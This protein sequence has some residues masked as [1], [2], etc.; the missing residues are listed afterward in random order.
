M[1]LS[2]TVTVIPV[3]SRREVMILNSSRF[4]LLREEATS[5]VPM[6]GPFGRA[7]PTSQQQAVSHWIQ[8]QESNGVS[9]HCQS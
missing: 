9:S 2:N 8:I 4:H 3:T 5:L 6:N 7:Q 1:I